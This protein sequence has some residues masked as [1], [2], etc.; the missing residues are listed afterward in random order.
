MV[1]EQSQTCYLINYPRCVVIT[2]YL[3]E[4]FVI[5]AISLDLF[6]VP[7][8]DIS[9]NAKSNLWPVIRRWR[10]KTDAFELVNAYGLFRRWL[11]CSWQKHCYVSKVW[12]QSSTGHTRKN[13]EQCL[14]WLSPVMN[15]ISVFFS[16]F[17]TW[18][19]GFIQG[20]A[21]HKLDSCV[22]DFANLILASRGKLSL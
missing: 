6:Q 5:E 8:T 12:F 21:P 1:A 7:Y 11:F 17:Y 19:T 18:E 3:C 9:H 14:Q 20:R 10:Q 4:R 13:I 15:H 22:D 2:E 16:N